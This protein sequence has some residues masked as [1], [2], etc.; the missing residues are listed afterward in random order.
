M[1]LKKTCFGKKTLFLFLGILFIWGGCGDLRVASQNSEYKEKDEAKND[2]REETLPVEFPAPGT[3]DISGAIPIPAPA[4]L[5]VPVPVPPSP[6]L[7]L[8]PSLMGI[9]TAPVSG[10]F[11]S[12]NRKRC[13]D[14]PLDTDHD[15]IPDGC[16]NCPLVP[17]P[18][19]E[20][21]DQDDIG[22]ACDNCINIPNTDQIDNDKDS[23]GAACDCD[24]D[25]PE[26]GSIAGTARYVSP[27]GTDSGDCA[28]IQEPCRSIAYAITQAAPG[29]TI[30]LEAGTYNESAIIVTKDLFIFGKGPEQS[31]VDAQGTNRVFLVPEAIEAAF[32][33]L[34]LTGGVVVGQGGGLLNNGVTEVSNVVLLNNQAVDGGGIANLNEISL[35]NTSFIGNTASGGGGG[36][37]NG[38]SANATVR[39]SII[40][41]NSAVNAGG[42]VYN[43]GT[44]ELNTTRVI[45]N[46]SLN[47]GGLF[48]EDE[49]EMRIINSTITSNTAT[50]SGGGLFNDG[51]FEIAGSTF[52]LNTATAQG[53]A[54]YQ[55]PSASLSTIT[56]STFSLN[57]AGAG[58]AIFA[59]GP[60][61]INSSFILENT[62][63]ATNGGGI[64][65]NSQMEINGTTIARNI[66]SGGG[67]IAT[68]TTSNTIV[69]DSIFEANNGTG[70]GGAVY[71]NGY[72]EL[73]RSIVRA[74]T[75]PF[76]GGLFNEDTGLLRVVTTT[77]E[78]NIAS[79]RA[80]GLFS[81]GAFQIIASTF[82][83]NVSSQNAGGIFKSSVVVPTSEIINSTIS[84]NI[85]ANAGGGIE[86]EAAAGAL[87]ITVSTITNNQALAGAG[88]F[89]TATFYT[90]IVALQAAGGQDCNVAQITLD[91]NIES[92]T[93]CGFVAANDQQNVTAA[94][95]NLGPLAN[96]G[97]PT[98]THELRFTSVAIDAGDTSCGV[99]TCQR[100]FP[101][102]VN[103]PGVD[104]I[105]AQARCDIGAF[106]LQLQRL[107]SVIKMVHLCGPF[108]VGNTADSKKLRM[109]NC[110]PIR[111]L[112]SI[113]RNYCSL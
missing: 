86:T 76:G 9:P 36:L 14:C 59:D 50:V 74:N 6:P 48:N 29:D 99:T 109:Q 32:C 34:T 5:P 47:G 35:I 20:D 19:Q 39:T 37:Y 89:G 91:Y 94:Q 31:T 107:F 18:N 33:G 12:H 28:D 56:G 15:G 25:N 30:I 49:G 26:I 61:N 101:R 3:P 100:G 24:D 58:G 38:V 113:I 67:G 43:L 23:V 96:N 44:I 54:V 80:G 70:A 97:G 95:L 103:I 110:L 52:T 88:I 64:I 45:S 11:S 77:V 51:L 57:Q 82:N 83:D 10:D 93:S 55:S 41:N 13:D 16:D 21:I 40:Q 66:A 111:G 104:P 90:S 65:N 27:S 78:A 112:N 53:G 8:P 2:N 68:G 85:A 7:G 1:D 71:N 72:F 108:F 73:N 60:L 98:R 17:N 42:G 62:A 81:D 4:P 63:T 84:G 102:P 87:L 46:T 105:N 106:E 75:S 69:N 22:D 79:Q 92:G